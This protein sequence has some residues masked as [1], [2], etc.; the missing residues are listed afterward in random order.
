MNRCDI[1][2]LTPMPMAMAYRVFATKAA[3]EGATEEPGDSLAVVDAVERAVEQADE[4]RR[5]QD[6]AKATESMVTFR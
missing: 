1:L 2:R 3:K 5:R 4:D 6:F